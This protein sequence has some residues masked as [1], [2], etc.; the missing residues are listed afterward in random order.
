DARPFPVEEH[1]RDAA[2]PAFHFD[3]ARF[4]DRNGKRA[5]GRLE[6]RRVTVGFDVQARV[7]GTTRILRREHDTPLPGSDSRQA[8][9]LEARRELR[10]LCLEPAWEKWQRI[11]RPLERCPGMK[12]RLPLQATTDE[13]L[14][15]RVAPT[16]RADERPLGDTEL[17]VE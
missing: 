9:L 2:G 8:I 6:V 17:V 16:G 5:R 3:R 14:T 12:E 1:G 13:R 7:T 10:G 11:R 15:V 4:H